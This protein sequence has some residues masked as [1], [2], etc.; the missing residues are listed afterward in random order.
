MLQRP[1]RERHCRRTSA[2]GLVA[3]SATRHNRASFRAVAALRPT[4]IALLTGFLALL[5]CAA[6]AQAC[7]GFTDIT[8]FSSFCTNVQWLKNRAITLGCGDGTTYCPD[9]SVSRLQMAAFMNRVGNVLE[10]RVFYVAGSSG[11]GNPMNLADPSFVCQTPDIPEVAYNRE[12]HADGAFSFTANGPGLLQLFVFASFD[13]G[14]SW[15]PAPVNDAAVTVG[16]IGGVREH[17][18]LTLE[19]KSIPTNST[20]KV[21]LAMRVVRGTNLTTAQL[22]DWTCQFQAVVTNRAE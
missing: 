14:V 13:S 17:A 20:G 15:G 9:E 11:V 6:R 21:R 22:T 7:A 4:R 10:P 3:S 1:R 5:P 2:G 12:V 19:R 18:S 8:V 16:M